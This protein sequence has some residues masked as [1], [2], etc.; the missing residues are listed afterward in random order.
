MR[1]AQTKTDLREALE[2]LNRPIGLVPTMGNLHQGHLDLMQWSTRKTASTIATIFVNP[3]QFSPTEDFSSY[4][5]MLAEDAK[6]LES[7]GVDLLFAPSDEEMYPHGKETHTNVTVPEITATLC[8]Q[9][10][11]THFAGVTTV[12]TKLFH[13]CQPDMAFF[14][15]K[16]WQ[17]L[18]VIKRMT[19]ELDFPLEIE[20]VPTTRH[21]DGLAMSSRNQYLSEEE[22]QIAPKLFETLRHLANKCFTL[23][24]D[25]R[26]LETAGAKQLEDL[27]F[28]P[29]YVAIRDENTLQP[30]TKFTH[31]LRVFGAAYLGKARLIDNVS[32]N[33]GD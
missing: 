6:K 11:P 12:V 19:Q 26:E 22:R 14:G 21:S 23:N 8:G 18:A 5:R 7:N 2:E 33:L 30:T 1:I 9:S 3:L 4:P 17:Q 15:E 10:R 25:F 32:V 27:G 31:D 29:D 24:V 28:R 13:L 16:D 20:G